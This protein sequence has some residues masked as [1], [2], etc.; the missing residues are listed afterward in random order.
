MQH[1]LVIRGCLLATRLIDTAELEQHRVR[2][3]TAR[4]ILPA[5]CAAEAFVYL[6]LQELATRIAHR[7]TGIRL[8][9]GI[10]R[11]T[12]NRIAAD[13]NRHFLFYRDLVRAAIEIDPETVVAAIDVV[14]RHLAMP[15][16]AIAGFGDHLR[17]IAQAGILSAAVLVDDVTAPLVERDWAIGPSVLS[18]AGRHHQVRTQEFLSRPQTADDCI[19][20]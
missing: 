3:M 6:A 10:D 1:G 16:T 9:D 11:Q 18:E 15:G 8:P 20:A 4:A 2:Y 7:N 5:G 13:E 17:A 14:V 12:M 19:A